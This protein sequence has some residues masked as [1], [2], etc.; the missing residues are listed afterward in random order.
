MKIERTLIMRIL[1][2]LFLLGGIVRLFADENLFKLFF[3]DGAW[4]DHPYF[5]YIYRVLGAFVILAGFVI[6][7]VSRDLLKYREIMHMLMWGF[8]VIGAVML[9]TGIL[10]D[11]PYYLFVLDALFVFLLAVLFDRW[12]KQSN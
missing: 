2:Y 5:I 6:V 1:G 12:R 4:S 3:M 7:Q 8:L 11:L 9:V 10:T